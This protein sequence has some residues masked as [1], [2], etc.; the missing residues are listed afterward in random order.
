MVTMQKTIIS[1]V[2]LYG[3]I[4]ATVSQMLAVP[5]WSDDRA[6]LLPVIRW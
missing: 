4:V 2:W 6:A 5:A 3:L 1:K